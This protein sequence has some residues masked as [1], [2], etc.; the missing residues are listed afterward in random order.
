MYLLGLS[1]SCDDIRVVNIIQYVYEKWTMNEIELKNK[2]LLT[3][4]N[5][6]INV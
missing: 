4:A 1:I 6:F 2:V 5:L 3:D